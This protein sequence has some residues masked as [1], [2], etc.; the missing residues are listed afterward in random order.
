MHTVTVE[1]RA[2]R[3]LGQV[4]AKRVAQCPEKPWVVTARQSLTYADMDVLSNRLAHGFSRIGIRAGD[5]VLLM[6]ADSPAILVAWCGL[7]KLGAVEVPVNTHLRGSVLAH[8]INDSLATTL[9]VDRRFVDR[10]EDIAPRLESLKRLVFVPTVP[11]LIW[12]Q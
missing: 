6:L 5:T 1:T 7:A 12:A 11:R 9:V 3:T 2:E 10:V 8:V 4:L